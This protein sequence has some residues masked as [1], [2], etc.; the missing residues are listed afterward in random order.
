MK[1][2]KLTQFACFLSLALAAPAVWAQTEAAEKTTKTEVAKSGSVA[3]IIKDG[4]TFS[5]LAKALKAAD[6]EATLGG[7]DIYTVFAPTDEA[8][9]KLPKDA[10]DK[11]LLPEN[12]EKLRTLLLFHVVPGQVLS[13]SLKDDTKSKTASGD[14]FEID[15]DGAKIKIEDAKVVNADVVANNGVIHVID[16]VL[17]PKSLDGF[18]GLDD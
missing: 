4:A 1:T 13:T 15:V 8:F 2:I 12:K 5:I 17:V 7:K 14:S 6:L 16:K 9:G 18:A 3:D 10:L 11:L